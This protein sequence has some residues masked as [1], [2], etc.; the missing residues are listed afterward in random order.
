MCFT[1]MKHRSLIN[2]TA[3]DSS[4]CVCMVAQFNLHEPGQ[5]GE[6]ILA[7]HIFLSP[8]AFFIYFSIFLRGSMEELVGSYGCHYWKI[9]LYTLIGKKHRDQVFDLNFY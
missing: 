4:P 5:S 8:S 6:N 3:Q 9:F 2:V 1:E 7:I